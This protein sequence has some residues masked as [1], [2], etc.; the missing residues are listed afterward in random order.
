[1]LRTPCQGASSSHGG[2]VLLFDLVLHGHNGG[3]HTMHACIPPIH[4]CCLSAGVHGL[5]DPSLVT[6]FLPSLFGVVTGANYTLAY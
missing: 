2:V 4:F 1:M 3:A 6:T 5:V